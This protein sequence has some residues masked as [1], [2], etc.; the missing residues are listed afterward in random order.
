MIFSSWVII[1]QLDKIGKF[2]AQL[3]K[4]KRLTQK[5]LGEI[6]NI[7]NKVI[8][9][10][11]NGKYAPDITYLNELCT[12]L[13]VSISELLDGKKKDKE[14][15]NNDA[16]IN[17]LKFYTKQEKKKWIKIAISIISVLSIIYITIFGIVK[18]N[19]WHIQSVKAS[20]TDIYNV[21]GLI[22]YNKRKTIYMFKNFELRSELA[23][24]VMEPIVKHLEIS[25]FMDNDMIIANSTSFSEDTPMH[26]A[27]Q[28]ITI[29]FDETEITYNPQNELKILIKYI[30]PNNEEN[31]YIIKMK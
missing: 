8:S 29:S 24:T 10:W 9:K 16:T 21:E 20:N 6:I 12:V 28:N 7:D 3:R 15:N 14:D 27:L 30:N 11:E 17:S 22:V 18:H 1:M 19:E 26:Q 31:S 13:G 23:G 5:E 2:I 4:E 25:L